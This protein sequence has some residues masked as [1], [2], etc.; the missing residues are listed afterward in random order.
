[1]PPRPPSDILDNEPG[2]PASEPSD[3]G[4]GGPP[5]PPPPGGSPHTVTPQVRLG[6]ILV[7][8]TEVDQA[9][10]VVP[11]VVPVALLAAVVLPAVLLPVDLL[12][13]VPLPPLQTRPMILNRPSS[14]LSKALTLSLVGLLLRILPSRVS[15][16]LQHSLVPIPR[17]SV[18]G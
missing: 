7:V 11:L 16:N 5:G 9:V 3:H 2:D 6:V 17:N 10:P 13:V 14:L 12:V 8:T 18:H 4:R 1:M 15:K